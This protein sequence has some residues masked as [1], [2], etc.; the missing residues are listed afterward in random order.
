M[1]DT[2]RRFWT[3]A[4]FGIRLVILVL[5]A[6]VLLALQL[7]G[8]LRLLQSAVTQVTSPAQIGATSITSTAAD[9]IAFFIDL[10]TLRQ[11]NAE[12]AQINASLESEI[13]R[14]SEVEREN[15][16]LREFFRFAQARPGLDLRGAQIVGRV[17][18]QESTNFLDILLLDLGQ[19]HGIEV[20]MP[21][22]TDQGL[23]G[24]I[25]EVN[26]SSSKVLLI[27]DVNS[28]VNALLQ[29]SRVAGIIRGAPEGTL[30]MDYIQQG[31]QISVGEIVL[32]SGLGGRFPHSIPIG[33]VIEIRQRD[34]DVV[35]QAIVQPLIDFTRLELVSVVTNF[36]RLEEVDEFQMSEFLPPGITSPG[37][38]NATLTTTDTTSIQEGQPAQREGADESAP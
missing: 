28:A 14:L 30:L 27:T 5:G 23:V 3:L 2:N 24:R 18:G 19:E 9:V 34:I 11:R 4:D 35:Q 22:V 12:L 29:S 13:F 7:T 33:R 16:T 36:D 17:I 26:N 32:T 20:G 21:V 25:F 15:I 10:R 8:Q 1:R 37:A 6:L 31:V 38:V